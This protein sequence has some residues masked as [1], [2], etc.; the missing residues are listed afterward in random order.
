MSDYVIVGDTKN[1]DG[2]LVCVCGNSYRLA[3][4]TLH[5]MLNSPTENDKKLM[6]GHS[7][8]R[9]EEVPAKECWWQNGCD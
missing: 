8:L 4:Q 9:V 2:C 6:Q 1:Y 5:R 3:Q 7:N